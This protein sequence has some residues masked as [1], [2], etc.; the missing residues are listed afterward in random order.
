MQSY[1]FSN[2]L[3]ATYQGGNV[4]FTPDGNNLL[5]AVGN[6]VCTIDLVQ[7]RCAT[8]AP[9]SREDIAA[10]A[11]SPDGRLLANIDGKGHCMLINF[12]RGC[13]LHRISF[14]GHVQCVRWSPDSNW[15]AVARDRKLQVWRAPSLRLGWQM[16]LHK[17]FTG[18][19]DDIVDVDWS[20][21]SKFITTCSKDMTV[22]LYAVSPLEGFEPMAL[23]E[24]RSHVRGAFFSAD[25]RHIFSLSREGAFV[26]VAYKEKEG[27]SAEM[28]ERPLYCRPGEWSVEA[29]AYC[30]QPGHQK[31]LRCA[32]DPASG[33]FVAGFSEGIFMLYEMPGLQTLQ[34][35]S[36]GSQPLDAV[37]L[38]A[39]GDW[40][41]IGSAALGQLFVWEWRSETYV[42]KQ[43]GHHWGVQCVAYS[44]AGP[45]SMRREKTLATNDAQAGDRSNALG[46]RLLATGGYDGKVKLFNSQSGLCF[47]TFAEHTAPVSALCFTPQGNAVLSASQDGSIRAFDLLRYRN[48]RTFVCP[49]EL[50]Q[51]A[52]LAVDGAGEIVAASAMGGNYTIYV[53]S[54][55][56]GNILEALTSHT[57][58]VLSLRFSP[59]LSHPGQLVSASWDSTIKVWDL[60][61]GKGGAAETL[62][63][64]SS[65]LAVCFDPRGNDECAASCLSGQILFW[66]VSTGQNVGSIDGLR[67]IQSGRQWGDRFTAS[68][69]KGQKSGQGLKKSKDIA[70]AVNLNQHYNSIAYAKSG[71][72]LLCGSRNSPHVCLYDTSAYSLV[73]RVTLTHNASLSGVR[74]KLDSRKLAEMGASWEEFDLS[75]DNADDED[76]SKRLKRIRQATSLPGVTVGEAKDAYTERELHVWGVAFSAD[77]QQFSA[78][79]TH[80]VFVYTVDNGLGAAGGGAAASASGR[81]VPQMLT[82]NVSAPAVLRALDG[83][84]LSRAM[85]LALALN[86]YGLL[87]KVYERIP[88]ASIPTVVASVGAPL[89]PALLWFLGLELKPGSGSP[90]FQ[91]HVQWVASVVDLHFA[92]LL[93]LSSGKATARTGTALEAAATARSDVAALSL[94]LLVELSQRHTSMVKTFD[95][96]TYLLRYLAAAPQQQQDGDAE[97][98]T[99]AE[100]QAAV[101]KA[102]A[103]AGAEAPEETE[104]PAQATSTKVRAPLGASG[105]GAKKR[106][107]K[108]GAAAGS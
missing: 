56:T 106:R 41:A 4:Q 63:C 107:R 40:V 105:G 93:E 61:A 45:P 3:G 95:G 19:I 77:M 30:Q 18:H 12:A 60:Y 2:L 81:F 46:G 10:L 27:N 33:I 35:L 1:R 70:S 104:L 96:N 59:S 13:V 82:K 52:G 8:L 58:S 103:A 76:V 5:S 71:E 67:D 102:L 68:H 84:D 50:C 26:T 49:D 72:L 98:A 108:G 24:H 42:L 47:V 6:R 22:R 78:A 29:K 25:L 36:L 73:S 44:P 90:H 87:R 80:G 20:S 69:T 100:V 54:I 79:T 53:W 37:A 7:G 32:F 21:D 11:L 66:N 43:Q 101:A 64:P 15:L 48:F 9:E 99:E 89:L 28:K 14:K 16:V 34:T 31:V 94:Q 57:S 55:Q 38:G 62:D 91:F 85:I 51:F 88:V 92:T 65:V 39:R 75:D 83:G 97:G 86:D 23:A 17:T 74:V